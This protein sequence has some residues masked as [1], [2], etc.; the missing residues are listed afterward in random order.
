MYGCMYAAVEH[1]NA[2]NM[3]HWPVPVT[4]MSAESHLRPAVRSRSLSDM[5]ACTWSSEFMYNI[6]GHAGRCIWAN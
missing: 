6:D 5:C 4:H 3:R 1:T 2:S